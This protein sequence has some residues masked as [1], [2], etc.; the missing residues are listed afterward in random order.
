MRPCQGNFG[1]LAGG[2]SRLSGWWTGRYWGWRWGGLGG[3]NGSA[4]KGRKWFLWF[5]LG[6]EMGPFGFSCPRAFGAFEIV[7]WRA[8]QRLL[9]PKKYHARGLESEVE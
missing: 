8:G 6:F 9:Q 1:C 7:E 4:S 3:G 5:G 2:T